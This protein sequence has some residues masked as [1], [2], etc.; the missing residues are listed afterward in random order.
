MLSWILYFVSFLPFWVWIFAGAAAVMVLKSFGIPLRM[1][2]AIGLVF[3]AIG[4]QSSAHNIGWA[5]GINRGYKNGYNH[6][7]SDGAKQLPKNKN[8][9]VGKVP[10]PPK[11]EGVIEE[12]MSK[13]RASGIDCSN[14]R[15]RARC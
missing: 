14:P 13:P 4:Y 1:S 8:P 15:N 11:Y 12:R 3:V 2:I 9:E 5:S 7:Y 10:P 6:G